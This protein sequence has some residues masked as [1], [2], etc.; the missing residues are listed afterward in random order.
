MIK[1]YMSYTELLDNA[2]KNRNI[3]A[4][5]AVIMDGNGRWAQLKSKSRLSGHREGIKSVRAVTRVCGDLGVKHLTLFTFSTENWYRPKEE[6][7]ALMK[8]LMTTIS[9][10]LKELDRNNIKITTIGNLSDLPEKA[11]QSMETGIELTRNNTGMNLNL[12]LS[13]GGR[14]EILRAVNSLTRDVSEG[15]IKPG[16]VNEKI[17]SSQLYTTDLPDPD[18]LI[19]TGGEKRISNFLLWQ[20]AYTEL[21]LSPVFW[22]DFREKELLEAVLDFQTRE[23]RFG[24]TSSQ[25]LENK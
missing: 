4:H 25:I 8:L 13:Y 6:V 18:L 16:S 21:Y 2:I 5:I 20:T 10:E 1:S 15:K 3:P 12:A 11:R 14:Q 23:R 7:S 19:R 22:P 17:F 9:G 24:K